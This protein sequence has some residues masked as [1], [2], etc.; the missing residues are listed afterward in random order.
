MWVRP[1]AAQTTDDTQLWLS[2]NTQGSI[3]GL[4]RV[5]LELH[6]RW[7]DDV[8]HFERAVVRLQ[9]G[10]TVTKHLQP[11]AWSLAPDRRFIPRPH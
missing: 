11:G 9:G 8:R 1:A 6:G 7:R 10:R 3:R 4:Y 5:S 2:A